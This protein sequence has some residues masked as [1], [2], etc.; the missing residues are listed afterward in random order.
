MKKVCWAI[1]LLLAGCA[2]AF[3]QSS[4]ASPASPSADVD[5]ALKDAR[6]LLQQGNYA[7]GIANLQQLETSH[8]GM[9]GLPHELGIA[10][11]RSG[12]YLK[13]IA[14]LKEALDE[15][16]E[17]KEAI[18]LLGL[19]NYLSGRPG[20]A[21]PLLEKVQG[22][23]PEANVDASYILGVAYIQTKN[24]GEARKA[25]AHMFEVGPDTAAAY[26][27]TARILLRQEFD[28]IAEEY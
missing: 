3:C 7:A 19:S 5:S 20:E 14:S 25:F 24:Y 4:E 10:Y 9:K 23:Y 12:D 8:P 11:Y 1:C 13:A 27:F 28:P 21:I 2:A 15:D 6:R 26:L 18:Q 16:P 22:W 17:D